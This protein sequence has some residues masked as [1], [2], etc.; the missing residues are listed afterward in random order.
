MGC[1]CALIL[2]LHCVLHAGEGDRHLVNKGVEGL[3]NILTQF[4]QADVLAS[5]NTWSMHGHCRLEVSTIMLSLCVIGNTLHEV[6]H[7]GQRQVHR[8]S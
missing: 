7:L 3:N 6:L 4:F 2:K 8:L 1:D 5:A